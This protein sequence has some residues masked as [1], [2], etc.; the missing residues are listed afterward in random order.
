[1]VDSFP[2]HWPVR[3]PR[4]LVYQRT[5]DRFGRELTVS[6]ASYDVQAQVRMLGGHDLVISTNV[7][8]RVDGTGPLSGQAAPKDTGVAVYFTRKKQPLV[9][10]CDRY[11]RLEA[12]LRAIGLH[13]EALRGMERWG[14][15]TL[16]Q[17]FAGYQALPE[18]A[19]EDPWWKV[20]GADE[21]PVTLEDLQADYREAARRS[22][23]DTGGSQEAFV[24]VQRA[25]QAGREALGGA[26]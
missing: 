26:A 14:V 2:L 21:P 8:Q 5:T 9:F 7:R 3:Q 11:K 16:D 23:P 25:F 20:L 15:G 19:G 10:A 13:I 24:R 22:H 1:M 4:T 17:T 6:L 18:T 12:N